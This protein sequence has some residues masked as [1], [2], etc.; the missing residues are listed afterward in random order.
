MTISPTIKGGSHQQRW[1]N[2]SNNERRLAPLIPRNLYKIDPNFSS[3]GTKMGAE[4]R[5]GDL[6]LL[7]NFH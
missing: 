7:E 3:D 6:M 4:R 5:E 2:A 1:E